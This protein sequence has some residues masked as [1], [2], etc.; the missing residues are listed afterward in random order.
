[1]GDEVLEF[2]LRLARDIFEEMERLR[3][4]DSSGANDTGRG[5]DALRNLIRKQGLD[6]GVPS[7]L[8]F[9]CRT[10]ERDTMK[11]DGNC[12]YCAAKAAGDICSICDKPGMNGLC[13][14]CMNELY[15][16]ED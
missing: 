10:C 1:M 12:T 9:K 4:W 11:L 14:P 13:I 16:V 2:K 8:R 7:Q 6:E 15:P 5:M 3:V